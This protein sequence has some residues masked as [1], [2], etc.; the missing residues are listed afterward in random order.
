[1]KPLRILFALLPLLAL[2]ACGDDPEPQ[3]TDAGIQDYE[4]YFNLQQGRCFEYTLA[5]T[6][7]AAPTLGLAVEEIDETT[8]PGV[9]AYVVVYRTTAPVMQDWVSIEDNA[10]KLHKR[11]FHGGK[12]FIYRPPLTLLEAPIKPGATIT[13]TAQADIH[14]LGTRIANEEHTLRVDVFQPNTER[15][16]VG[17]D[18]TSYAVHFAETP[19]TG[20]P[21]TRYFAPGSGDRAAPEGWVKISFNFS[22][23]ESTPAQVYK[24]QEIRELTG[25]QSTPCGSAK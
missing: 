11:Y 24:L 4:A 21:E 17:V 7:Q 13:S 22:L 8:F 23:N 10:L 9:K 15:F 20:R 16:P 18:I 6:K 2:V 25:E 12:E 14:E 19:S 1:M 3:Q 5:D